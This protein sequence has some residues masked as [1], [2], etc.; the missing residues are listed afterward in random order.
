MEQI[1]ETPFY[2]EADDLCFGNFLNIEEN[3]VFQLRMV[4]GVGWTGLIEVHQVLEK[5]LSMSEH[6]S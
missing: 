3:K 2:F 5:T 1:N 4:D 6:L